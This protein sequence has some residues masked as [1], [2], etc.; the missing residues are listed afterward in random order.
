V[1]ALR[2]V[3]GLPADEA[4]SMLTISESNQRVLLHRARSKIRAALEH[5]LTAE[6][7]A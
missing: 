4:C 1:I 5:Y 3:D 7:L 2:D 6:E